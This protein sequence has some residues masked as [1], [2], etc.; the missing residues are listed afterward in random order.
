MHGILFKIRSNKIH[1]LHDISDGG[2]ITTLTEMAIAS[3]IGINVFLN[4]KEQNVCD[5]LFNEELGVVVEVSQPNVYHL[6]KKLRESKINFYHIGATKY[7]K[8]I[9]IKN[10]NETFFSAHLDN[11]REFWE[12]TSN[13]LEFRQMAELQARQQKELRHFATPLKFKLK[14]L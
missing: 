6:C 7:G 13:K 9:T 11:L 12:Y 1:S 5:F 3:D 8:D 14:S 4:E 2:L 10:N